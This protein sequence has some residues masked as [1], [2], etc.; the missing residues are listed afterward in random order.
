MCYP[1]WT[2]DSGV[3]QQELEGQAGRRAWVCRVAE[4]GY[5][6]AWNGENSER[7]QTFLGF[8]SSQEIKRVQYALVIM[9]VALLVFL[10]F[11]RMEYAFP[12]QAHSRPS[13]S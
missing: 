7:R 12:L 1:V 11:S 9:E 3:Q 2:Q 5:L 13:A 6:E 8:K 4:K 10:S